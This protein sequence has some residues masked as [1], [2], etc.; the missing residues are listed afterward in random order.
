MSQYEIIQLLKK[1]PGQKLSTKQIEKLLGIHMNGKSLSQL[2]RFGMIKREYITEF[3]D[4]RYIY[5]IE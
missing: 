3:R 1:F 2:V 5:W 4:N